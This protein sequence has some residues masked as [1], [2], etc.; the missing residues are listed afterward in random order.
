MVIRKK[1]LLF[2]A[3]F[4]LLAATSQAQ[5]TTYYTE[6]TLAYKRGLDFYDQRLYGLALKEFET[7][8]DLVRPVN[9]PEWQAIKT[10]AELYAAKCAVRLEQPE[11][12]IRVLNFLREESPSPVAAQAAL[13][14][15]DYYFNKR[16]YD[17]ALAYYDMASESGGAQGEEI[18]FKRGYSQFVGKKFA[19]ARGTLYPLANNPRS[20]WFHSANYYSGCAAFFEKNY[21]AALSFMDKCE[22]SQQYRQVVPYMKT[23]ILFAQKNYD[24][25]IS[26]G[27]PKAQSS[28]VRNR[29]E[30]NQLVGQ[31]YYEKGD[32]KRALPYL[33]FAAQNGVR[34]RP[35]DYYQL[36][37]SQHQNG[38][39]KEAIQNFEQ[40]GKQDS[41]L[42]QN[43]LYHL[44]DCYLRV[45]NRFAA[46]SAFAQ[47]ANMTFDRSIQE[48]ALFNYG[49]LSYEQKFDRDALAA[50][51]RIPA[52]SKYYDDAQALMSEIFLNTRDYDRAVA[53]L[54]SIKNRTPRMNETYQK[55]AFYRGLQ[56]Y[57]DNQ[58]DEARRFFNKSLDQPIDKRIVTLCSFWLGSIAHDAG[59]WNI[60]RRHLESFIAN[61]KNYRDLPEES[62]VM[63][64]HYIQ[65]YN[66]LKTKD[67]PG[68]LTQFRSAIDGIR[69]NMSS[70]RSTQIRSAVLGDA[71]LRA[72]DCHFKRN[73]YPEALKFYDEA[74]RERYTGYEYAFYQKAMIKG[75]QRKPLD[76]ALEL[77]E[78]LR[79]FPN[80]QY[81][82]EALFQLGDTY[83]GMG[84]LSEA[85]PP[86][87]R[88]ASDFRGRSNLVNQALLKLGLISYNQGNNSAAIN[89]YKQVFANNP[90]SYEAKDALA[91]LEE[92]YVRDMNRPDEY[93]AF[94][95]TVPGYNITTASK[96]SVSYYGAESQ[97]QSG[98]YQQAVDGF[99][100]YLTRF[101]NGRYT[102]NAYFYR[103]ESYASN[104]LRKYNAALKDYAMVVS[105]GPSRF[106]ARSA[107]KGA[108]IALNVERDYPQAIALARKWE[109]S[110][111]NENARFEAQ[112]VI[113]QS[114]YETNNQTAVNEYANKVIGAGMASR[115]QIA[116]AHFYQ[117]KM[118]FNR[119]DFAGAENS[120]GKVNE[121]STSEF[122]A[123]AWY[124]RG[125]I[126]F[127]ARRYNE[128]ENLLLDAIKFS[129]GYDDW[130]ARD[131]ILLSDVYLGL[132]DRSSAIAALEA[133]LENYTGQN[134]EIKNMARDKYNRL[135]GGGT[136]K[137]PGEKPRNPGQLE[138]DYGN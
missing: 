112:L 49:K 135:G 14:V 134:A 74:V 16:E 55:V 41:L 93:F 79:K 100:S 125:Q 132:N 7:A 131:L 89:Y 102:L 67:Y 21:G 110:A 116:R 27:A 78:F 15:G 60:S 97:F 98:R 66:L 28:E 108:L 83:Q 86:L 90:E 6:A 31:A 47:A 106:Y 43:A 133:V 68:A 29:P 4:A 45:N 121:L 11:A 26:Y 117:G 111:A 69:A 114:A 9:E 76:K 13:E 23:Q 50:F 75:L 113:L 8:A 77:E 18:R 126:L 57:Q 73:Q 46:R 32:Y 30:L 119:S 104:D 3:F 101:P 138:L 5:V 103:A 42:G 1:I 71:V 12:E 64:A 19:Q 48:E 88:L 65:G 109:E 70:I 84:K 54:E 17:R 20:A 80:S 56:L 40:L 33:E 82:D 96:D 122:S 51:Q 44:S 99:T 130:I 37:Y 2:I 124:L 137:T 52:A 10:D 91:A 107:E 136:P 39:Y 38:F 115:E 36:G 94:L 85:I 120:L 72:G 35:S 128:A 34:L 87:R 58:K 129:A 123:E 127:S 22:N 105:K 61:A 92:I 81:V 24:Q 62:S 63:M 25:V 95:E 53:T 118:A 59:E